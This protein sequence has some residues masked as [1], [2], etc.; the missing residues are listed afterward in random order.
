MADIK[1]TGLPAAPSIDLVDL[2]AVVQ[3]VSG[4]PISKK[5]PISDLKELILSDPMLVGNLQLSGNTISS[6]TG[7]TIIDSAGVV[8]II[9]DV[10]IIR[11]AG[12]THPTNDYQI[13]AL[14]GTD[15]HIAGPHM[16]YY[17][18]TDETYPIFQQLNWTHDEIYI[19]LDSYYDGAFH[20]SSDVGSN[21]MISKN[22]DV[23]KIQYASGVAVG[24]QITWNTGLQI[25]TA[26]TVF[27]LK[28]LAVTKNIFLGNSA[29]SNFQKLSLEGTVDS[30]EGPHIAAYISTDT[31]YPVFQQWNGNHDEIF[32]CF[33]CYYDGSDVR[34]S[35]TGSNYVIGK[36]AGALVIAGDSGVAQG[37]VISLNLA[38]VITPD[39][40][41]VRSPATDFQANHSF[42]D[43]LTDIGIT[44]NTSSATFVDITPSIATVNFPIN[45]SNILVTWSVTNFT[46][47]SG[48]S[49]EIR[50]VIAGTNGDAFRFLHQTLNTHR[51]WGGSAVFT[52][53][54]SGNQTVKLQARKAGGGGSIY[55]DSNDSIQWTLLGFKQP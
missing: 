12:S 54:F 47:V 19:H 55:F 30:I 32:M 11:G 27:I 48:S 39:G 28:D 14:V 10:D 34:S 29:V 45:T 35:D 3:D 22:A 43:S 7:D 44:W 15:S 6:I 49:Y 36:E 33:D 26:G 9:Q 20:R 2:L 23:Y 53:P 8:E 31:T 37:D 4:T 25:D 16:S 17:T 42:V 18:S 50:P 46:N 40:S 5:A 38:L 52:G 1:F 21:Y 41:L 51:P 24:D 13:L